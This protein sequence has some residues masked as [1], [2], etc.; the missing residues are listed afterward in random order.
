MWLWGKFQGIIMILNVGKNLWSE[1]ELP[2]RYNWF[3]NETRA[4][5]AT[6][7]EQAFIKN[8]PTGWTATSISYNYNSRGFRTKEF[9][10]NSTKPKILCFGCS[11]TEGVGL[12]NPW[13]TLL[14]NYFPEHDVYNL[15]IGGSSADTVSRLLVNSAKN[16]RPDKVFV[17]W[18]EFARFE[19]LTIG[20]T[21]DI[22]MHRGPWSDESE[23]MPLLEDFNSINNHLKNQCIASLLSRLYNFSLYEL[24]IAD[25][26]AEKKYPMLP[27]AR[28]SMHFGNEAHRDIADRFIKLTYDNS[29][30]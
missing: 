3:Y 28:D 1:D 11:H 27:R 15:G 22:I 14:E 6:D 7:S 19:Q 29:K 10:L 18:P 23:I 25:L 17:L 30:I 12:Q 24:K 13:P 8:K 21:A 16:L 9:D 5:N 2:I 26:I 20:K 4:W